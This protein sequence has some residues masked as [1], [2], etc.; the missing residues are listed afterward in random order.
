MKNIF[1]KIKG[2]R[3]FFRLVAKTGKILIFLLAALIRWIK[4]LKW[5]WEVHYAQ[6]P[7]I[8]D[9]SFVIVVRG[10][11]HGCVYF[12]RQ[13]Q[14]FYHLLVVFWLFIVWH[15]SLLDTPARPLVLQQINKSIIFTFVC[16]LKFFTFD[17]LNKC[18]QSYFFY[19]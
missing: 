15:V 12:A 6:P 18:V 1:N 11:L 13:T 9:L 2:Y 3:R 17:Y 14:E 5:D 8:R 16:F 10:V 7:P 19:H 4:E